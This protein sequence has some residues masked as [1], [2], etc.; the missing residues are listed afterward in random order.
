MSEKYHITVGDKRPQTVKVG[1]IEKGSGFTILK[2]ERGETLARRG[3]CF[4]SNKCPVWAARAINGKI[5]KD[6][7]SIDLTDREYQGELIGMKWGAKGGSSIDVRYLKGYPSLDVLYQETRLNFKVDDNQASSA[8]VFFLSF[9]NG[10]NDFD[11]KIEPLLIQHLKWHAY[12]MNSI[13]RDPEFFTS[14]FYEKS[15][16]QEERLDSANLDSK[17][18]AGTIVRECGNGADSVSKCKNLFS[19]VKS[20]TDEEPEDNKVYAYLKMIADKKPE[21]FIKAIDEYKMKVSNV[22]EKLKSY[23]IV[24]TTT[25]GILVCEVSAGKGAKK[26][27]IIISDLPT[28]GEGIFDYLLENFSDPK[29][30]EA[31]YKLIQIT[32]K[33]K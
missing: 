6:G 9:P 17:F 7:R 12:N 11:E 15:F 20:V 28:K 4:F 19:I 13:S 10:D 5:E 3:D 33:L 22:F 25:D 27:E 14:M 2:E 29:V 1:V 16:E 21:Q 18:E 26:K 23:D 31:T 8:D 32:D 24:D 30:F